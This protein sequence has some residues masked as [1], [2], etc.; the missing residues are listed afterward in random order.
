MRPSAALARDTSA[1]QVGEAL[2]LDAAR[3]AAGCRWTPQGKPT[4]ARI[5]GQSMPVQLVDTGS[6]PASIHG[7]ALAPVSAS[8]QE[9]IHLRDLTGAP[10]LLGDAGVLLGICDESEIVAALAGRTAAERAADARAQVDA[11]S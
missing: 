1:P 11:A 6:P 3:S 5:G 4:A 8:L 10:V 9:I 2:W 7:L